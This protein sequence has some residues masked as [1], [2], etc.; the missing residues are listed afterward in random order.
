[1]ALKEKFC[2]ICKLYYFFDDGSDGQGLGRVNAQI[3]PYKVEWKKGF[4]PRCNDPHYV[5]GESHKKEDVID[6]LRKHLE[7]YEINTTLIDQATL[8]NMLKEFPK[9]Y[10]VYTSNGTYTTFN[11]HAGTIFD[12][13]DGQFEIGGVILREGGGYRTS[14]FRDVKCVKCGRVTQYFRD[15]V[16]DFYLGFQQKRCAT[17]DPH[18]RNTTGLNRNGRTPSPLSERAIARSLNISRAEYRSKIEKGERLVRVEPLPNGTMV[19]KF[20]VIESY[21]DDKASSYTP[22]YKLRCKYCNQTF[23]C[24]QKKVYQQQHYCRMET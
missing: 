21:W 24:L 4:C 7:A 2:N 8:E 17:C 13:P 23:V 1:M 16:L 11:V 10:A 14:Y 12:G 22:K 20:E 19:G 9:A 5:S 18:Y 15:D 6:A 3:D